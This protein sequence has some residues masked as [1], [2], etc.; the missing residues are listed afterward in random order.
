[1]EF[2]RDT[3]FMRTPASWWHDLWRDGLVS[4]NGFI[5]ADVYGG[6]NPA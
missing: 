6:V 2:N 5:G 3:L 4:G 1:M